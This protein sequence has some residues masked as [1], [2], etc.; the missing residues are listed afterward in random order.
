MPMIIDIEYKS[1][2]S[3]GEKELEKKKCG[4]KSGVLTR[5][6]ANNWCKS[7]ILQKNLVEFP[8]KRVKLR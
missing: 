3:V 1:A 8:E 2:G 7:S 4:V 6:A 5:F